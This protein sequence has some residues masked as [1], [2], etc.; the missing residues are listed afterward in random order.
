MA[1]VIKFPTALVS[2]DY[3]SSSLVLD[4]GSVIDQC[5]VTAGER[6]T[7]FLQ[8][9]LLYVVLGGRV[10]LS[11]G[12]QTFVVNK[13]EM[14]LLKKS[15]S[16]SYIKEGNNGTGLFESMLFA[17]QDNLIKDFLTS[18]NVQIPPMKE[19]YTVKVSQM[20]D[21][22]IAYCKSLSPY[23][24]NPSQINEGLLRL[25]VMELLYNVMDCSKN[26]FRQ[27]LQL[28]N[29]VKADIHRIVEQNYTSPVSLEDLAYLSGRS[30]S[31]FKRDFQQIYNTT[32]AKYIREKRLQ[33][34]KEL[35]QST[36]MPVSEVAYS[37]GFENPTHFTH[38]F[39]DYF[40]TAPSKIAEI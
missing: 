9:H 15:Q 5:I 14:I 38:I 7:F 16:V 40:G 27:I 35:L 32:P 34:A 26:I 11:C 4:G 13:N 22:L 36:A 12:N 24:D 28:R 39:K 8:Q 21:A 10:T 30:L 29:P 19:E 23:F 17:L 6:G 37:L 18:Q 1:K 33:K 20:S 25:K 2:G 31:S 3:S